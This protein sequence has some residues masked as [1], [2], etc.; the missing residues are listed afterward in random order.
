M[1]SQAPKVINPRTVGRL[2]IYRRVLEKLQSENIERTFSRDLA[3]LAGV[4][5]SL[6]RQ[7]LM[8]VA[9]CGT[10]QN[11]YSVVELTQAVTKCL[12]TTKKLPAI[13]LGAGPLGQA[14][15]H[16]FQNNQ[17]QL[18]LVSAF[19]TNLEL[20]DHELHGIPV[21]H[22]SK[23]EEY[24]AQTPA[25]V[26]ILALPKELAQTITDRLIAAGVCNILN[27]T[28]TRLQVPAGIFI[29]YNDIQM[30]LERIAFYADE[31]AY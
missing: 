28:P 20:V 31:G 29:E 24:L 19:E 6:V 16:H 13:L 27:F 4:S 30:S 25:Q 18:D 17:P 22:V 5:A 9:T 12:G 8:N 15:L 26:A 3:V 7:D 11:G 21:F 23:L 14:L 1:V 10:P 2:I